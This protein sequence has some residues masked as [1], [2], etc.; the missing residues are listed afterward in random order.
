MLR[1][2]KSGA[3]PVLPLYAF[4]VWTRTTLPLL[5]FTLLYCKFLLASNTRRGETRESASLLP[6][7]TP[8]TIQ[9]PLEY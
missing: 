5:Y 4:M 9:P 2:R 3:V 8:C 7:L 6:T 1:L